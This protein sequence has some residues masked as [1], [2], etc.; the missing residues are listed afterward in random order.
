MSLLVSAFLGARKLFAAGG[1]AGAA[2]EDAYFRSGP[3]YS[4]ATGIYV[5]PQV[6]YQVSAVFRAVTTLAN[7]STLPLI[8]YRELPRGGKER[9]RDHAVG[10][11]V[12]TNGVA[13]AWQTGEEWRHV[14]IA[15]AALWGVAYS[16]MIYDRSGRLIAIVPLPNDIVQVEQLSNGRLR[17]IV[18]APGQPQRTIPQERLFRLPGPGVHQ[19]LGAEVLALSR[20]AIGHWTA[21]ERFGSLYFGQGAQPS[22]AVKTKKAL[23]APAR[24]AMRESF[25]ARASGL[26]NA[27]RPLLLEED[28]DLVSFGFNSRDSQLVEALEARVRDFARWFGIPA[29]ILG[30]TGS[31]PRASAEQEAQE[32]IDLGLRPWAVRFEAALKRDAI[33]EDEVFVEHLFDALLRG[34]T[35]DRFDAYGVA[36][37]NGIMSEN[38]VRVRENLEP[39]E[40]LWEPRRSVNQ[41]RGAEPRKDGEEAPTDSGSRPSDDDE[42]ERSRAGQRLGLLAVA[43]ARRVVG[44]EKAALRDA[45]AKHSSDVSAFSTWVAEFY[46]RTLPPVVAETLQIAPA[47]A[48]E[49]CERRLTIVAAAGGLLAAQDQEWEAGAVHVLA[50]LAMEDSHHAAA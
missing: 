5:T 31:Q 50:E 18:T 35:R 20:E 46:G 48:R 6:A 40:G 39:V 36:I 4:T 25:N 28:T 30:A 41:D 12:R 49:Y 47:L 24:A 38:E 43:A 13:N 42:A 44:R 1:E 17:A 3:V 14:M 32:L 9:V 16:E 27:W 10:R 23:S 2:D 37:M 21:I 22:L 11:L 7:L 45:A 34:A 8:T 15:R 33:A 19:Y 29:R 26:R